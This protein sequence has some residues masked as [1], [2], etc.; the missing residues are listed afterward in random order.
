MRIRLAAVLAG[1]L[2][3]TTGACNGRST[4]SS[5]ESST[6]AF[7]GFERI[8]EPKK[9]CMV[10]DQY[11]GRD[12]IPVE[13]NGRTYFGC[14]AM[15]KARLENDP[16]VRSALDP[17]TGQAVDKASAIMGRDASGH[18]LYF[19]SEDTYRRYAGEP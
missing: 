3:A 9:V 4:S 6:S 16:S 11:M 5:A 7:F 10:N 2:L 18:V 17:V 19:A 14:C 8:H 1:V 13:V 15:C 12:Q